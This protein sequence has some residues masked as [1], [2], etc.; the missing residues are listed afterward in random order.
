MNAQLKPLPVFGRESSDEVIRE[1]IPLFEAHYAEI[2]HFKDI[3]L[4]IDYD[5]YFRIEA[6]GS[7]RIYTI[8]DGLRLAGY[9]IF[10]VNHSL[11]YSGSLQARQDILYLDPLYRQGALGYRFI[12]WCDGQLKAE[13]VDVVHHHQKVKHPVLGRILERQGYAAVD[14]IWSKRL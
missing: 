13:G 9:A 12:A 3:P 7:L 10:T 5:A 6:R 14:V 2:A 1:I 11:H 4:N 8:R